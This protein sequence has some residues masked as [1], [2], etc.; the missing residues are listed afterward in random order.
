M[1]HF[2]ALLDRLAY[3]PRRLGKLALLENYFR[4]TP[5]PDRGWALAAMTGALS[6]KHAK[7]GLV[8]QLATERTDPLLF[9]L[10]WD[11]VGDLAETVALM[12]PAADTRANAELSLSDVVDGLETT[13]KGKLPA[14]VAAWLDR[15]DENGRW[16]LLKL[17]T[18][19]LRI[20]VSARLARTALAQM[21]GRDADEIEDVWHADA[22]PYLNLFAWLEGRADAPSTSSLVRF[23]PP[24]LSHPIEPEEFV[25]LEPADYCAEWKWD[26][27]RVQAA[28]GRAPDGKFAGR[29]F[30]RTGDDISK[31]FP[32][33]VEYLQFDAVLDGELLIKREGRVQ[34]FNTLQQRLNRKAVTPKLQAEFP[35]FIRVYDLLAIGDEDLR[36]L[37]FAER[38]A[39][40][41]DFVRDHPF[42][43]I[44]LSPMIPFKT[45]DELTYARANPADTG[46]KADAE[47]V[48]GVMIKRRDSPYLA[49]RPK[50]H[51]FKWKRD[52]MVID[53][54]L[55][56]AQRGSGKRSSFYSDYTFGVWKDDELTPVGKAYF[57]FTDEE[58]MELD[59]FVRNNTTNRFGPVR[60][61]KHG[62]QKGLVLEV[63]FEGLQRS[64]RHKS[65]VAMR[66]PRISRIR[67][68]KAPKDAD[69]LEA[70]EKL[71]KGG[72]SAA[73]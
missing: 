54:V 17:I 6:F 5:D 20:G 31:S 33:L 40:L 7:P 30:S 42:A 1:N 70:L 11:F 44:D 27:I 46:V 19:A 61:V 35:P 43:P 71:L 49:G 63:A 56:Y 55:M 58:L 29:L 64:T 45:W 68:D 60:E 13:P 69:T 21:G 26:G 8:R 41:E 66:F 62:K 32:D 65:G 23:Y 28:A 50:G 25:G 14:V 9:A 67:W 72:E 15:L 47:A 12:W 38:R 18:G 59:K 22:P 53:A 37:P 34:D 52:P 24:M 73:R 3:E 36:T 4:N 48:E 10:S 57:G 16:A 2:A 39:R 51:W